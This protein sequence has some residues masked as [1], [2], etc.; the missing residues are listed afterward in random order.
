[1]LIIVVATM[2]TSVVFGQRS[3]FLSTLRTLGLQYPPDPVTAHL[4]RA[5]VSSIMN[6]NFTRLRTSCSVRDARQALTNRPRWVLV[7]SAEGR[8]RSVLNASDLR[9]YVE[10]LGDADEREDVRLLEIPGT[11]RDVTDIDYRST[12]DEAQEKL[13]SPDVEALCVRRTTAPMITP[14]RGIII[15]EDIDNYRESA[16]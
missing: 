15:Q 13:R 12:V 3:V 1:M 9:A 2:V 16:L 7:E 4:Q 6:R 5:G 10:D 11:R 8:S 14:V